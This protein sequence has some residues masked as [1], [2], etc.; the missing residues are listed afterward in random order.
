[1]LL[2]NLK[3][4]KPE[5]FHVFDTTLRDGAQQEGLRLTVHD[6]LRIA[7]LLDELG[8]TFIEGG[9]PGANPNETEFF[10]LAAEKLQLKNATLVAFGATRRVGM[11]AATD[12]LTKALLDAN[13]EVICVVAKSH[14]RHVR[15]ALKTTQE[16]N[17]A[18]I[19]D[20]VTYLI[21]Q[22]R[23]VFVD[24]EHFFNGYLDNPTYAKMAVATAAEAGAEVVI[25]CD[26]NGGMLPGMVREIVADVAKLGGQLG[27]HCHND[28]G[29]AVANTLAG[30][31][32]GI[33]HVQ[34][35]MNGYGERTG[36][37]D[38]TTVIAN[39]KLKYGWDV[40]TDE[41]LRDL[42]R[43]AHSVA[44][45]TNQ[46][47]WARQP[48]L[49]VSSFAHKAGLHAS[50][51]KVDA[52]LYQHIDPEL[53]GNGMRML[54]S[55][56]AGRANIQ[57]KAEQL[58][59]DLSERE[60][61]AR[62]AEKVKEREAEGYSYEAADASFDLL[63]RAELGADLDLCQIAGWRV[64]TDQDEESQAVIR[65]GFADEPAKPYVGEGNGPVNALDQALRAALTPRYPQMATI[66]LVDYRVRLLDEG[67]G[68]DA[69]TRVLIDTRMGSKTWTTVGVGG[70]VVE[71]SWEALVE[72]YTYAL[73]VAY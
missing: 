73:C 35:T 40:I 44:D 67:R 33:M 55:D 23:R 66:E 57:I 5:T 12:P 17:L 19:E 71:A 60:T 15:D 72:A 36:N 59:H 42:T 43:I 21:S 54:I 52:N 58:G 47:P 62:L 24:C 26:T 22:G 11:T 27:I 56:M 32:A 18:M 1:M 69:T 2:G 31:D 3:L 70:N 46:T 65:V 4:A 49:G 51:I 6:K 37:A 8:V 25:L 68:T 10:R 13:T 64:F 53:V 30:V 20:T 38:L 63:I 14:D 61:A 34:G 39:L 48:Y 50:A 9:W 7:G 16:E 28:T 29:C 45:I 41:A